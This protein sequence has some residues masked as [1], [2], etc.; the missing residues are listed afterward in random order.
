MTLYYQVRSDANKSS[1]N[2]T[3]STP[4]PV[5]EI[6]PV[7]VAE[8]VPVRGVPFPVAEIVPTRVA[9]IVPAF[10]AEMVPLFANA[11]VDRAETIS[12]TQTVA[13]KFFIALL[14]VIESQ[15]Y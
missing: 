15:G 11:V 7:L 13:L 4:K 12:A 10:V 8:I 5:A 9:E 2:H 14:L 3:R 6:V 1:I